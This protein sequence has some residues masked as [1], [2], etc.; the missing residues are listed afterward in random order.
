MARQSIKHVVIAGAGPVGCTAALYLARAGIAVTLLESGD[1]LPIDLRASTWHPPT[2]DMM[3]DLGIV[4]D[5]IDVGL[6]AS[7]YQYRDRRTHDTAEFDLALLKGETNHPYRVQ[8]EQFKMTRISVERLRKMDNVKVLFNHRVVGVTQSADAVKIYIET[9]NDG[10]DMIKADYVIGTDGASSIVRRSQDIEFTGFTYPEKFLVVSTKYD[11]PS[12]FPNLSYVNYV[13]DPEEWCVLLKTVDLW[14]VLLPTKPDAPDAMLLSDDYVQDRLHHLAPRNEDYDVHHRTLYRVHQR[15]AATF[16]RGRVLLAGDACHINN[17][18]GGMGMNGG[19][20][21]AWNLSE[22][23]VKIGR[24][25]AEEAVLDQYDRQRRTT[26]T[27][28]ILQATAENKKLIENHDPDSQKKKQK[29]YM[30]LAADPVRAKQFLMRTSMIEG[31]R[32]SHAIQ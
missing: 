26:V 8:C 7:K 24:G 4:Q 18:L 5:I 13:S 20:H 3:E 2:L 14:R 22:K 21:D 25:E 30:E 17:P 31:L 11:L 27:N 9:P 12:Y 15:V 10:F 19:I 29:E 1:D 23:L 6:I 28:V 16:R 32:A